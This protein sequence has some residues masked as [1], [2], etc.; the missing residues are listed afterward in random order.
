MKDKLYPQLKDSKQENGVGYRQGVIVSWNTD[1]ATNT[2]TVG[3]SLFT[4][5]PILNTSEASLLAPGDVVGVISLGSSFAI[6]GRLVVP[7][8]PEA[9][10]SIQSITNRIQAAEDTSDGVRNSTSWGDLTGTSVGPAVTIRIGASGRALAFWSSEIG[11]TTALGSGPGGTLQFQN[12]TT[13]HVGIEVSGASSI[14]P[15]VWHALNVNL[16]HGGT[17]NSLFWIQASMMHLFTG[18]TPGNNT[19]TLKYRHDGIS[20]NGDLI[21][22][23]REIAVFAL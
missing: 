1:D 14:S 20:A 7:G 21:F 10:S 17:D 15:D 3:G 18:L 5:L 16:Q 13:P 4:N 6:L 12:K 9:V 8:T 2:V 19:F 23:A 11:A 22:N